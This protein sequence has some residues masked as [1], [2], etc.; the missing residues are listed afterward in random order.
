MVGYC[1]FLWEKGEYPVILS[2]GIC[3][4]QVCSKEVRMRLQVSWHVSQRA[5]SES[6]NV[7]HGTACYCTCFGVFCVARDH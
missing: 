4:H 7:L 3:E 5:E 6:C 2:N 1:T